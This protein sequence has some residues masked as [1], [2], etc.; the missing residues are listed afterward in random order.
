M[1]EQLQSESHVGKM[2]CVGHQ[3]AILIVEDENMVA[4][5][6]E[7]TLHDHDFQNVTIA[8]SVRGVRELMRTVAHQ[9]LLVMLDL[10]LEDGDSRVLIDEFT[11]RGIAVIV[12]TG[13]SD[14]AHPSIPVL[15]KPFASSEMMQ[16][17]HSLFDCR[18]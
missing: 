13:Y 11:D 6:I 10:K 17:I 14:F 18:N 8:S 4:W 15:H 16:T 12:M 5:D 7:Q 3:E 1:P 9:F 2:L